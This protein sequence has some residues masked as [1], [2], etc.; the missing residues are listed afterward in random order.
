MRDTVYLVTTVMFMMSLGLG[1]YRF[2][3]VSMGKPTMQFEMNTA[4][5]IYIE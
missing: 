4:C 3:L 1:F 5:I 2:R